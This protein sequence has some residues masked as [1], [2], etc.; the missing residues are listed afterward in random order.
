M[1][2]KDVKKASRNRGLGAVLEHI[3]SKLDLIVEGQHS[4][5]NQI[6]TVDGKVDI[7]RQEMDYKFEAVFDELHLI[8][9]DLKEKVGR[10]EFEVLQKRVTH[11]EKKLSHAK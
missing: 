11:L 3:D 6:T 7:V 2:Q 5:Q 4:L 1:K 9:N 8:R 10:D